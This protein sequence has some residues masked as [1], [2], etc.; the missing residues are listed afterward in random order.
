MVAAASGPVGSL[1]GQLAKIE[2]TRPVGIAGGWEKC[3]YK[4]QRTVTLTLRLTIA[5]PIFRLNSRL[6]AK[7]EST[8]ISRTSAAAVL[9]LLNNFARIPVCGLIAQYSVKPR[10]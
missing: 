3:V 1:V 9:P 7:R 10:K 6:L 8:S 2:G 4:K 5:Q